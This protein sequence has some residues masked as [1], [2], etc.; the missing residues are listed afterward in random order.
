MI[1][2]LSLALQNLTQESHRSPEALFI[3]QLP[4]PKKSRFFSNLKSCKHS[5]C[6]HHY[7]VIQDQLDVILTTDS[8]LTEKNNGPQCSVSWII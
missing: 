5:Y 6:S 3:S 1:H 4:E 2:I 8:E 7:H